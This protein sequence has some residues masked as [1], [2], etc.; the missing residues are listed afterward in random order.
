M[1]VENQTFKCVN[2]SG[3]EHTFEA[4]PTQEL[5]DVMMGL[6][7]AVL[8]IKIEATCSTCSKVQQVRYRLTKE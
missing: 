8:T 3:E 5:Y 1:A 4:A 6:G 7:K 2:P